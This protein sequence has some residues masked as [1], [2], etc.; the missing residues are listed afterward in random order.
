MRFG[1]PG[2]AHIHSRK[3]TLLF[4]SEDALYNTFKYTLEFSKHLA[5][6]EEFPIPR[7]IDAKMKDKVCKYLKK[8]K[9]DK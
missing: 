9:K 6:V 3:D 2:T 4:M 8:R 5:N 7:K 1:A